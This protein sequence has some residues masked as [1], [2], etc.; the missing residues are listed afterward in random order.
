MAKVLI[1]RPEPDASA[2]AEILRGKSY[3]PLLE[4]LLTIAPVEVGALC[5]QD[6]QAVLLTSTNGLRA[7]ASLTTE[8]Y[9]WLFTVGEKTAEEAKKLGFCNV[10]SAG[11]SS[12]SLIELTEKFLDPC[13]GRVLHISGDVVRQDMVGPLKQKR[14]QI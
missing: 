8:R 2:L 14:F 5:L 6:V 12:A 7:F 1:T 10:M 11:G 9:I 4:P 13:A 3:S